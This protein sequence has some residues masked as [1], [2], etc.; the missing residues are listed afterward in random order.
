MRKYYVEAYSIDDKPFLGNCSGQGIIYATQ[1]RR[2]DHY[3]SLG[4][5]LKEHAKIGYYQIREAISREVVET[6]KRS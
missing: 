5:L 2:T 6:V 3:K 1:Y 4:N